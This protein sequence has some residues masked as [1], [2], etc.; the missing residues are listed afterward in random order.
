MLPWK[1]FNFTVTTSSQFPPSSVAALLCRDFPFHHNRLT[2]IPIELGQ[3]IALKTLD[4][5]YNRLTTIPATLGQCVALEI[6]DFSNNQLATIPAT[7]RQCTRL[8]YFNVNYNQI[9]QSRE[10]LLQILHPEFPDRQFHFDA[11]RLPPVPPAPLSFWECIWQGI[12]SVFAQV[13]E[14]LSHA[15]QSLVACLGRLIRPAN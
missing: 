12:V 7:L 13:S 6:F 2:T 1:L 11:Q 5:S 10:D 14:R 4:L 3:C 8:S 9:V 15:W